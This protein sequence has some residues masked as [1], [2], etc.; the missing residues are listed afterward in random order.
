MGSEYLIVDKS[1]LPNYYELVLKA[2]SLVEDEKK[3]VSLSCKETGISRSTFYKY[4]DKIFT[5]SKSY[6]KKAVV[7][8]KLV[9]A[10]GV[11]S[12]V[13]QDIYSYGGNIITINSTL[14]ISSVSF[15][16]IVIDVSN[17][18]IDTQSMVK[19]LKKINHVKSA[20]VVAVE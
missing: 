4:K 19:E 16:T 12:N 9:D 6:G 3:S 11:L 5:A 1:I 10:A 18:S 20:N 15:I 17:L 13:M 7:T 2:K 14:P 8:L